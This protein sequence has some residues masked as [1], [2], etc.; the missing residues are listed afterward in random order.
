MSSTK[1]VTILRTY[2]NDD[3]IVKMP[4]VAHLTHYKCKHLKQNALNIHAVCFMQFD[5]FPD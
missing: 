5:Q 3:R 2:V 4:H 1:Q